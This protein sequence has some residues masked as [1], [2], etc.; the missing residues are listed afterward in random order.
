MRKLEYASAAVQF[1]VE[2]GWGLFCA[3]MRGA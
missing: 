1:L 2:P 3:G